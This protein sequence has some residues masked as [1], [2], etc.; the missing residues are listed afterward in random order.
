MSPRLSQVGQDPSTDAGN[1]IRRK[2]HPTLGLE[3]RRGV[4]Q[5]QQ[6]LLAKIVRSPVVLQ[7]EALQ[8][9]EDEALVVQHHLVTALDPL[10][11]LGAIRPWQIMFFAVG[12]PGALASLLLCTIREPPRKLVRG[13][14]VIP[15]GYVMRYLKTNA[16]TFA[17]HSMGFGFLSLVSYAGGAWIPEYLRRVHHWTPSKIGLIFGATQ[18]YD[19]YHS[20]IGSLGDRFL[21][22]RV[23]SNYEGQLKKALDHTGASTK[24]MRDEL[25]NAVAALF[26]NKPPE[27]PKL[28]DEEFK[29]RLN[30]SGVKRGMYETHFDSIVSIHFRHSSGFSTTRASR[31][32]SNL[33]YEAGGSA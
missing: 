22:C 24:A 13:S 3:P 12:I 19:D 25:A 4:E 21:L 6:P 9:P 30:A 23:K 20:V 26:A 17:C 8:Y 33:R 1:G 31:Q 18:A 11:L 32:G 27:P 7:P 15:L 2:P 5:G 16:A 28:S 29:R 14:S 10:P